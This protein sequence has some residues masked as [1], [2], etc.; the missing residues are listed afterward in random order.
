MIPNLKE[1]GVAL[2]QFTV[3]TLQKLILLSTLVLILMCT[4]GYVY[5]IYINRPL[6][7][8]LSLLGVFTFVYLN[9]QF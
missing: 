8:L 5:F 6:Y 9:K 2:L 4:V 7:S 1:A 3:N